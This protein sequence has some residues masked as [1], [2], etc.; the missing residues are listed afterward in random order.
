MCKEES[1]ID[2]EEN[3][4]HLIV[5]GGVDGVA[6]DDHIERYDVLSLYKSGV[7]PNSRLL[8]YQIKVRSSVSSVTRG[9]GYKDTITLN[10]II[11]NL[12][13]CMPKNSKLVY[14]RDNTKVSKNNKGITAWRV[15]KCVDWLEKE[16]YITNHIGV[17]AKNVED[18][19][20][21]YMEPTDRL[22]ALWAEKQQYQAA[23]D[24]I[25]QMECVELR[26]KNKNVAHY[27]GNKAIAHMNDV[28]R[29]LNK[30]NEKA[31]VVDGSG[32]RMTNIYCRI[33]N[34]TFNFGGRFYRADILAIKN[35]END[36]RLDIKINGDPIVE[37]DFSNLHFRIASALEEISTDDLPL[38]VY[39]GII[40]DET[41]KWDRAIVKVAVN[42][43]FNCKNEEDAQRAIQLEINKIKNTPD[44]NYTL[45]VAKAVMSLIKCEYPDFAHMFCDSDSF[46]RILQNHDSNLA[47][48]ILEVFVEKE[49][50]CLPVHDSFIVQKQHLDLLCDTMGEK[51][52]DR[53][54][55]KDPIPV[56]IKWKDDEGCV[57]EVKMSV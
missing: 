43:M 8:T 49:I 56:G 35:K 34:E 41:N 6:V 18:R 31:T 19:M 46:G 15:K 21:S 28:V 27:R 20:P 40:P 32:D 9:W 52:R 37:V 3:I 48:D 57:V 10:C 30:V 36:C 2:W 54:N 5:D 14:S 44:S 50:P 39:S 17:G 55:T 25:E 29:K 4:G 7:I 23:I 16:G 22:R 1:M 13:S 42:I 11:C 51:F 53:F 45:G 12:L 26:D 33:F 47:S 24:Y 38:D